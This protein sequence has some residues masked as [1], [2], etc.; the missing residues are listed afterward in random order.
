MLR[1]LTI[2]ALFAT[3]QSHAQL[4]QQQLD[5]VVNKYVQ[6]LY[7]RGVDTVCIYDEYCVGCLFYTESGKN[8]CLE[9]FS[10]LPTYIFWKE[11]G[12]VYATRKDAC[13]D[14]AVTTVSN[15]SIWRY[16]NLNKNRI[17]KEELKAPQYKETVN[18]KEKITTVEVEHSVYF[19]ITVKVGNDV[20]TKEI[21]NFYFTKEL[22]VDE[23]ENLSYTFNVQT[24]L[25]QW[26]SIL[27]R[28]VEDIRKKKLPGKI[29]S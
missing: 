6:E 25:Y 7:R 5:S 28:I 4:N 24:S 27:Q 10:S 14:F 20:T 29:R 13:Y 17:K 11:K 12:K 26:N 22:G 21:N 1:L 2:L 23:V 16:Y 18:G 15:D 9:T 19:K 3:L 8:L